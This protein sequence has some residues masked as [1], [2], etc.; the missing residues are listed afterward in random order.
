MRRLKVFHAQIGFYDT[1]VAAPSQAAA[2]PHLITG[3][4]FRASKSMRAP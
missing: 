2:S 3:M 1:A 4:S